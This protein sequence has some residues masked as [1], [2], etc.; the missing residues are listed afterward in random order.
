MAG[1]YSPKRFFKQVPHN[2]IASYFNVK[3]IDLGAEF[4]ALN[5]KQVGSLTL[6]KLFA[7]R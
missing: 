3:N 5:E 4:S 1:Q 7:I 6:L 2:Q